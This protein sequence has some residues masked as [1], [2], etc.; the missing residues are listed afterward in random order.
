MLDCTGSLNVAES[1]LIV[2]DAGGAGAGVWAVTVGGGRVHIG[3][4]EVDIDPV[5]GGVERRLSGK[6]RRR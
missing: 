3:R 1:E 4:G 5:V 6:H 2:A